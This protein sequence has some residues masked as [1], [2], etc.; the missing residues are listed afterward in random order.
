MPTDNPAEQPRSILLPLLGVA[1]FAGVFLLMGSYDMRQRMVAAT[2]AAAVVLW[3][4]EAIPLA[5]TAL[6]STVCLVVTGALPSK[7]AFGAYGD[8]IILLFVGS[9][10]IAKA[11]EESGLDR[12]IAYKLLAKRSATKSVSMLLLS[13]G[14]IS[15]L[16]SLFVSNTATT[17]MLLPIGLTILAAVTKVERGQSLSTSLLL[18]LTW[19]S[20]IAVGTIIGTPPNVIGVGLIREATG[21]SINFVQWAIFAMPVTVVLLLLAWWQLALR[22]K[23]SEYHAANAYE[24]AQN[25]LLQLGKLRDSEKITLG[26]FF[27]ALFFWLMPGI[28][29][30]GAGSGTPTAKWWSDR[31]PEAVAA[32]LGAAVLFVIPAKDRPDNRAMTWHLATRIEWGTIL[33]FAGGLALGKATFESGLAAKVGSQLATSLNANDPWMITAIATA[34]AIILSELASNTASATTMVPVAIALAQGAGV[35][36]I[37]AA[38][39]ATIGANLGF[40]LPIST[41]PNAIVYSTGLIP[42][43]D[44]LRTGILF[45]IAGFLATMLCLRIALPLLG[46]A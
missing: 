41:A 7:D 8:Q 21:T 28:V 45:D 11:M 16:I 13:M 43:R 23:G 18:M 15:C 14:A 6:L 4:T 27:V 36:P 32:L 30:Y 29:E 37:P 20:S 22:A 46:L 10:I 35:N 9:F 25:E 19:G 1:A 24:V 2:F 17:A 3:M 42:P 39:G 26:A 31:F 44:M 34:M 38:L 33:L 5:M 40:M 12:R